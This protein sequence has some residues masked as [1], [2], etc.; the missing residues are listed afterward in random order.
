MDAMIS[1]AAR[2]LAAGDTLTALKRVALRSDP[3]ALA[4]RGIAMARLGDLDRAKGLLRSARRAFGSNEKTARARCSVAEAEIALVSRDLNDPLRTLGPARAILEADG[5]RAN[6]AHAGYLQARLLLLIGRLVEAEQVLHALDL[7]L[8]PPPSRAGYW[9]VAAGIA[10]RRIKA[11]PARIALDR[12][13]HAA[14]EMKIP[15]LWA[16]VGRASRLFEAPAACLAARGRKQTLDLAGVET[17]FASGM[18]IIDACRTAA[19]TGRTVVPLAGRPVL[20]ALARALAESWPE[21]AARETLLIR[22]FRARHADES[23]RARL[24]VEIGRLR[25]VLAPLAELVATKE[26]FLLKPRHAEKVG[27]LVPPIE[28]DHADVLALL[29]DGEAWSSSALA[30]ALGVG[31]R[32]IQRALEVLAVTG[33]AES[34][35]RGR[36][37]RWIASGVP[38]FPTSLLLPAPLLSG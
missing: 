11:D 9:L 30:L 13:R 3:P 31:P 2:A 26:G 20:F 12:A 33:Q 29:A 27:V 5:D 22:A 19:R 37:C 14:Q 1:A 32:T 8:L 28:G 16:E 36:A 23:H 21:P 18:L 15:A 4:L 25:R 17:L 10:M 34:F 24:R 6:A 38:G 7:D 35:G